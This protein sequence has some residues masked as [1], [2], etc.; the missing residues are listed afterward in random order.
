M[1]PLTC[2]AVLHVQQFAV[3]LPLQFAGL[4]TVLGQRPL[5][6]DS[7]LA[8]PAGV[9][10]VGPHPQ[11]QTPVQG[12]GGR[13]AGRTLVPPSWSPPVG[14]QGVHWQRHH[15]GAP[16]LQVVLLLRGAGR[17]VAALGTGDGHL[18]HQAVL[19]VDGEVQAAVWGMKWRLC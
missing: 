17:E 6:V 15:L 9:E 5:P 2:Q 3:D 19:H 14:G 4:V 10:A 7:A 13:R 1:S 18:P 16:G 11:Q 12:G 8:Q